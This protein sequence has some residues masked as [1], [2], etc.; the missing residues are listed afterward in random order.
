VLSAANSGFTLIVDFDTIV[1]KDMMEMQRMS[2]K[3]K[4]DSSKMFMELA[5]DTMLDSKP[6][7]RTDK[8]SPLVGA[9]LV[10]TNGRVEKACRGELSEGDHAEYTL[11]ER[12]LDSDDL[13]GSALYV[14][15]EPCAPGARSIHKTSCAERI[16]NR[17]IAKVWVGIEDPD[18]LVDR[19]GMQYLLDHGVEVELFDRELQDSIRLANMNFIKDAEERASKHDDKSLQ[20]YMSQFEAPILSAR[21]D[22][23]DTEEI[24]E[25]IEY[26]EEFKFV[27]DSCCI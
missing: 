2:S 7:N 21:L 19:R 12:K 8:T 14:T 15:L 20:E 16:V 5:I 26:N 1:A 11:L 23:L 25:F 3:S 24:K 4:A 6:E 9:V 18:P 13:T 22:D 10:T 27:Y 17:R